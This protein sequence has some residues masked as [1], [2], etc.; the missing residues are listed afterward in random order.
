MSSPRP[1]TSLREGKSTTGAEGRNPASAGFH[2]ST[3]AR[4]V[5]VV[6]TVARASCHHV[7]KQWQCQELAFC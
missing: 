7:E 1:R 4:A 3:V 5:C 2:G 6:N